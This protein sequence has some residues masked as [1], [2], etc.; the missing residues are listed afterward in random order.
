MLTASEI[1][2]YGGKGA[3]LNYVRDKLPDIPIPNYVIKEYGAGLSGVLHRFHRMKKPVIVR[4][5]SP[6]EYS[7]FEGIFDSVPDVYDKCSLEDAIR[8]VEKSA[9]SERAVEYAR[10]NGF[11]IDEQINVVIQEQSPSGYCGA[12]MRHPNNPD[13]IFI[14]YFEGRGEYSRQHKRYLF[15]EKVQG[16][17]ENHEII[18]RG[19]S[20]E[21][22]KFLVDRYRQLESLKEIADG[23]SLFVEFGYDPFELYQV[24]PFKRIETADFQLPSV[25]ANVLH[26]DI[27]FGITPPQG[28]V[29]PVIRGLG[30]WEV[31][32]VA[33]KLGGFEEPEITFEGVDDDL[34]MN[35]TNLG[36]SSIL[37]GNADII[38]YGSANVMKIHY[39]SSSEML[40][41]E[42]YCFMTSSAH[43]EEYDVD[44]SVPNMRALVIGRADNFLVHGL[45]R[46]IKKADVSIL[47]SNLWYQKMYQTTESVR[48]RVRIISNGKEA[49]VIRE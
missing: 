34:K 42:R 16:E 38:L 1:T 47:K 29:L 40:G 44:L 26:A 6:Y 18:S 2:Q 30:K 5:S 24:R 9:T 11:H 17:S 49:V 20:D 25:G 31:L 23:Q 48:D 28:I 32:Q 46:L 36:M 41:R 33:S 7:D 10:Q 21:D 45:M 15:D 35:L 39:S 14:S 3:I 19:I 37:G 22:A 43:Q 8:Q 12:M 13:L 27:V 4:S